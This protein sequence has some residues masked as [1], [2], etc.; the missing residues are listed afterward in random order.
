MKGR[1][2]AIAAL[3]RR[4]R[5]GHPQP[6]VRAFTGTPER[7]VHLREQTVAARLCLSDHRLLPPFAV[8]ARFYAAV[9]VRGMETEDMTTTGDARKEA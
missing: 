3:C 9:T 7:P 4:A 2:A 5:A 8:Y 6:F 1:A